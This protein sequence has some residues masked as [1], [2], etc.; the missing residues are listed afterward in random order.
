MEEPIVADEA[1][2]LSAAEETAAPPTNTTT[3]TDPDTKEQ[4]DPWAGY[5]VDEKITTKYKDPSELARA[6]EAS[7]RQQTAAEQEA[8]E[9]RK[10]TEDLQAWYEGQAPQQQQGQQPPG[11]DGG[12]DLAAIVRQAG[13]MVDDRGEIDADKLAAVIDVN[14]HVMMQTVAQ[15]VANQIQTGIKTYDTERVAPVAT[16]VQQQREA[17]EIADLERTYGDEFSDVQKEAERLHAENP[18]FRETAGLTALFGAAAAKVHGRAAERRRLEAQGYTIDKT[19]RPAPPAPKKPV[20]ELELDA[21]EQF[22]RR[23]RGAG[24]I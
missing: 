10:Y 21:M 11:L 15:M 1:D 4:G 9:L 12:F 16:T 14:N 7:R 19:G 2:T 3:A 13:S 6:Y 23:G 8:A 17:Q 18:Q 24:I 20:E 5:D 22:A